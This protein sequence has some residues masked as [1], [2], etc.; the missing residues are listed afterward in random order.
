MDLTRPQLLYAVSSM[1]M[2]ALTAFAAW[3]FFF[4]PGG[5]AG[6]STGRYLVLFALLAYPVTLAIQVWA[7]VGLYRQAKAGMDEPTPRTRGT[8]R[9]VVP[10]ARRAGAGVPGLRAHQALSWRIRSTSDCRAA[11]GASS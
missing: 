1:P 9:F 2:A 7:T 10:F 4:V 8:D 3:L 11:S 6:V 5:V